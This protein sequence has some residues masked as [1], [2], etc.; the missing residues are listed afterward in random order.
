MNQ[1]K[2]NNQKKY[3]Y[4]LATVL[5]ASLFTTCAKNEAVQS[6]PKRDWTLV[7]SDEFNDK[8]V[9]K[10]NASNWSYDIGTG[11]DGWGNQELQYYTDRLD[12][13]SVAGDGNLKI[14]AKKESLGGRDYISGR[15]ISKN[16][17][18]QQ[19]GRIEARIKTPSG[20]G[21]WPAFWMLG[22][23]IDSVQWPN[24]GEIDI[25][26]QKGQQ[27]NTILSSIHGA[28]YSGG[29]SITKSYSL[30][31]DRFDNDF[32]VYAVEWYQDRLDFFVDDYL[33]HRIEKSTVLE[34]GTWSFDQPFY[35]ILNLAVG[36]NLVGYPNVNTSFPQTM[37][38]DYV[39]VYK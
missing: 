1:M 8:V 22:Q 9:T 19:Y 16:K 13:V 18:T 2:N 17:V 33:Y 34:K 3:K 12:V 23:N 31:N 29:N 35:I 38:I 24:C 30:M 39:R 36:G 26:E 4:I 20:P 5:I 32:H 14:V 7:W 10:P 25:L 6:L 37:Q 27:P 11:T 28:G 15:I 21:I